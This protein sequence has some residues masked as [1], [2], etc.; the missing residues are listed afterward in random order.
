MACKGSGVQIPSAPQPEIPCIARDFGVSGIKRN[1]IP[2][3]IDISEFDND[4][5]YSWKNVAA[6]YERS[7][8]VPGGTEE[9][10]ILDV[11]GLRLVVDVSYNPE[12][13]IEDIETLQ[14]IVDSIT[15]EP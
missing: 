11:D 9:L 15:I 5:Y 14:R 1:E 13:S 4:R 8:M 3:D 12:T 2:D 7:H 10:Y 6:G